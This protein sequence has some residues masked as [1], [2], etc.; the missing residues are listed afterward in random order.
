MFDASDAIQNIRKSEDRSGAQVPATSGRTIAGSVS[1]GGATPII[2]DSTIGSDD[3]A[4][5]DFGIGKFGPPYGVGETVIWSLFLCGGRASVMSRLDRRVAI[6]YKSP[7]NRL[8]GMF[9]R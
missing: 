6:R 5:P 7:S 1:D 4:T 9:L 2:R 8:G 3:A